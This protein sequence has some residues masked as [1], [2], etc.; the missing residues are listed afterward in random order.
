MERESGGSEESSQTARVVGKKAGREGGRSAERRE[1]GREERVRGGRSGPERKRERAVSMGG[2]RA[3]DYWLCYRIYDR[4]WHAF[5]IIIYSL[6]SIILA[7]IV[8]RQLLQVVYAGGLRK[9][10]ASG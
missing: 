2:P 5:L 8:T 4:P 7:R 6:S 9:S 3:L 10:N 1:G